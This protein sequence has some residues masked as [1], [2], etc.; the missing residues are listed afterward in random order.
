M[1]SKKFI[2]LGMIVGGLIGSFAPALWGA[3]ELSMSSVILS[4]I[5]G[6]VGIWLG[7]KMSR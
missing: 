6:L 7:L 1:D 3:S 5:G 2:Y 4:A